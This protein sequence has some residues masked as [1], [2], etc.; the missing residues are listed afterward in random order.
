MEMV[1]ARKIFWHREKVGAYLAG[2]PI[3]PVTL[4]LGLTTACNR[5]CPDCPSGKGKPGLFLSLDTARRLFSLCRGSAFGVIFTGGEPTLH[6]DFSYILALAQEHGFSDIT[7]ISNGSRINQEKVFTPLLQY[8]SVVRVSLYDWE[9]SAPGELEAAL[10]RVERLRG[11]I[12]KSGSNLQI[13]T[14]VLTQATNRESLGRIAEQ[15]RAAGAHWI[16]FHPTC[17]LTPTG[18][19]ERRDQDRIIGAMESC[20]RDQ[21]E[22]FAVHYLAERFST[23]PVLFQGYH[24][25]HFILVVGADGDNYLS[26]ETKY[27]PRFRIASADEFTDAGFLWNP[28]RLGKIAAV[29]SGEYP[30]AGS[31]NR[32]VL[33]NHALEQAKRDSSG[34]PAHTEPD[35]LFPHIL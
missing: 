22:G 19:R 21:P 25:A 6:P 12:E 11:R 17:V 4:E 29:H 16:Y 9:G 32:G 33:Y 7:V 20:R 15:V 10:R 26:S 2:S 14:S 8:A 27:Q 28:Q 31:R 34:N 24:A 23:D 30:A 5:S 1:S 3:F 13:G 18:L 35:F